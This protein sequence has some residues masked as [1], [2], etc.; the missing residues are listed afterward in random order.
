MSHLK[1]AALIVFVVAS[2]LCLVGWFTTHFLSFPTEDGLAGVGYLVEI[3]IWSYLALVA[4]L[5]M[6]WPL[7]R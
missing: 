1:V 3:S 5:L 4:I 7:E 2:A 6:E